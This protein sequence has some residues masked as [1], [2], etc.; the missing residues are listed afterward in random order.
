MT[1]E[2]IK[3]IKDDSRTKQIQEIVFVMRTTDTSLAYEQAEKWIERHEKNNR[4]YAR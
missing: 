1:A 4:E 3:K 2:Q